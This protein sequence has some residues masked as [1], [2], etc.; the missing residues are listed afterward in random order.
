MAE[1]DKEWLKAEFAAIHNS[2]ESLG[3]RIDNRFD[4]QNKRTDDKFLATNTLIDDKAK[5]HEDTTCVNF[6][7]LGQRITDAANS[8]NTTLIIVG[9]ALTILALFLRYFN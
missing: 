7:H 8:T 9:V 4:A 6:H 2:I 1:I 3:R 5:S